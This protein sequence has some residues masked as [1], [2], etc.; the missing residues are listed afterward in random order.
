MK[1]YDDEYHRAVLDAAAEAKLSGQPQ[2]FA[3]MDRFG[4]DNPATARTHI[5]RAKAALNEL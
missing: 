4:L 2:D 3:V 1:R 5:H